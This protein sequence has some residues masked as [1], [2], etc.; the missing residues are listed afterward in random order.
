M[1]Y[2]L[3]KFI[4]GGIF[5]LTLLPQLGCSSSGSDGGSGERLEGRYVGTAYD[6]DVDIEF[7]WNQTGN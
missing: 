5:V 7:N 1:K 2:K 3:A 6:G 4:S